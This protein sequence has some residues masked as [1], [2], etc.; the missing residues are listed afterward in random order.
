MPAESSKGELGVVLPQKYGKHDWR[1]KGNCMCSSH[2]LSKM[3]L[4]RGFKT[5]FKGRN[6][7]TTR[8]NITPPPPKKHQ[9][10]PDN[11][12]YPWRSTTIAFE[13]KK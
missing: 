12:I 3:L 9:K 8:W 10:A 4:G 5:L 2:K 13:S 1:G 11:K 6:D 7:S